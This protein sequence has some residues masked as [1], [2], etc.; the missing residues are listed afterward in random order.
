[1]PIPTELK[2]R[3]VHTENQGIRDDGEEKM[4]QEEVRHQM[5]QLTLSQVDMFNISQTKFLTILFLLV[6]RSF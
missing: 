6:L 1:M 4:E 5:K 2:Q 3:H